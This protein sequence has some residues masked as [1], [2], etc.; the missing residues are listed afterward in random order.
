MADSNRPEVLA[1]I[2]AR[3]GSKGIPRKNLRPLAGKPLLAHSIQQARQ[4]RCI[5]RLV[6]S[7][8]DEEIGAVAREF[9]AEVIRR[10][11]EISGDAA[12]SEAA[13]LH[14]LDYLREAEGYEPDLVVFLQATSP[15]REPD[16]IQ[17]AV[18]TL[19]EYQA[20]SLFSACEFHGFLWRR[21]GDQPRSLNYDYGRRPRRQEAPED[22]RENGSIYVFKPVI[23][24]QHENRLGGKIAVYLMSPA[25]SVEV[26][27]PEDLE[28]I[29]R[30]FGSPGVGLTQPDWSQ[31][32][33]LILD[34]DG[35]LT[36]NRVLV[37]EKGRETAACH[38]GDGWGIARVKEA[39]VE[40]LVLST[41]A[42]P[43]VAARCEKLQVTCYQG[44]TDKGAVL[45][46]LRAERG[47]PAQRV[48]FVGNDVNDLDCMRLAGCGVAVADAHPLVLEQ[49]DWIL[50]KP[51]GHGAVREVCDLLLAAKHE[52]RNVNG[53]K[54]QDR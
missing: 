29:Q 13:L 40:V 3:G 9:G 1:I 52:Q 50:S 36:D 30:R 45:R 49:A 33:L 35:V 10:P 14:V 25:N 16:D 28:R 38:R 18:N 21:E 34:F 42:N 37:N 31:V 17:N 12:S 41:E 43:L 47:L 54:S 53:Q 6:V 15:L 27:R 24:R 8:D 39:G 11:A 19:Q 32:S 20:D 5:T 48:V 7:T 44:L 51:G 22:V 4:T 2:P 26:D 46:S 23:L